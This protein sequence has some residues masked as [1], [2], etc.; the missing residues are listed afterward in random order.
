MTIRQYP[1]SD[2]IWHYTTSGDI[3]PIYSGHPVVV[4][5]ISLSGST[6]AMTGGQTL[7]LPAQVNAAADMSG[8]E[9]VG[10]LVTPTFETVDSGTSSSDQVGMGIIPFYVD[11]ASGATANGL[12]VGGSLSAYTF[13]SRFEG[14]LSNLFGAYCTVGTLTALP[15]G[16]ITSAYGVYASVVCGAN[17]AITNGYGVYIVNE[18]T[19]VT[20]P[21][22]VYQLTPGADNFFAGKVGFGIGQESPVST[23]D[24]GTGE[25]TIGSINRASGDLTLEIGGTPV[26]TLSSS[27]VTL[28]QELYIGTDLFAYGPEPTSWYIATTAKP[29]NITTAD[30]NLFIGRD[31][32]EEVTTASYNIAVGYLALPKLETGTGNVA[33]GART[34]RVNTASISNFAIGYRAL[35]YQ[36]GNSNVGIGAD[37]LRGPSNNTGTNQKNVAIGMESGEYIVEGRDNVFLGYR[38]ARSLED[39]KYN[40]LI[41]SEAG[42]EIVDGDF[43]VCLGND[44]GPASDTSNKLFIDKLKSDLPLIYGEFDN[45]AVHLVRNAGGTDHCFKATQSDV[46]FGWSANGG[47]LV[48]DHELTLFDT[49]EVFVVD[50]GNTNGV[51]FG[52]S[53]D[54]ISFMGATP[55]TQPTALTAALGPLTG[56]VTPGTPDY[57]IAVT[58]S[59]PFGF[60]TADEA[61]SILSVIN[62]LITRVGELETKLGATSGLGLI[63]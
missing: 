28:A 6:I 25:L 44:S 42:W 1:P 24:G 17:S 50:C 53:G 26:L 43:N 55:I 52:T 57:A 2:E 19:N 8:G 54:K 51:Q 56:D 34:L 40:V 49:D 29:A 35:E 3:E 4:D 59:S 32:G 38:T 31:A 60:G 46:R 7:E 16:T 5:N 21:Y 47:M 48:E 15:T 27:A 12:K 33:I 36:C 14:T 63:A 37:T 18:T 61:K 9:A 20:S 45:Q 39:G 22:G 10:F 30:N 58:N 41:G 62:N 23:L 13:D 11:I